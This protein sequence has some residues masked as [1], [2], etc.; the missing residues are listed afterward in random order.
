MAHEHIIFCN[1]H[2][3]ERNVGFGGDAGGQ[4]FSE[5]VTKANYFP[6]DNK[7]YNSNIISEILGPDSCRISEAGT[8][9]VLTNN[10]QDFA[11]RVRQE[12][13]KRI[14][15]GTW[16]AKNEPNNV[17]QMQ[18][19]W[20]DQA[21]RYEGI[22]T[23]QGQL[24]QYVGFAINELVWTAMPSP[25]LHEI[26]SLSGQQKWRWGSNGTST[27]FEWRSNTIDI[28]KSTFDSL[29]YTSGLAFRRIQ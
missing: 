29:V 26:T 22:L 7:I 8:Y 9:G 12:Y 18:V 4:R 19:S 13:W 25:N 5:D 17:W 11:D 24:S 2:R 23:R 1:G 6:F 14:F 16:E 20:N 10:C 21:N 15:T 27:K 28:N 3:I